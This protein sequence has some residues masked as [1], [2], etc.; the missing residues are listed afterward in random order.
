MDS[1]V[2]QRIIVKYNAFSLQRPADRPVLRYLCDYTFSMIIKLQTY[3]ITAVFQEMKLY[4]YEDVSCTVLICLCRS[5]CLKPVY[6][7]AGI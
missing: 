1:C 4:K 3:S 6:F 7:S 2:L 5:L